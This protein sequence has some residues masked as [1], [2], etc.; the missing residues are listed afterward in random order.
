MCSFMHLHSRPA[1]GANGVSAKIS[2]SEWQ[3]QQAKPASLPVT[4]TCDPLYAAQQ[5]E[6]P[7][8][9][10]PPSAASAARQ[11]SLGLLACSC[12]FQACSHPCKAVTPGRG[13]DLRCTSLPRTWHQEIAVQR[14]V[15]GGPQGMAGWEMFAASCWQCR[16]AEALCLQVAEGCLRCSQQRIPLL[17]R[18]VCSQPST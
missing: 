2:S 10:W 13:C 6:G 7:A 8:S 14:E 11:P 1:S 5:M 15:T 16:A 9:P 3:M 17:Y 18:S 4:G 12:N